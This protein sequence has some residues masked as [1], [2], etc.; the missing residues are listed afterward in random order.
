MEA[1]RRQSPPGAD[2]KNARHS[3]SVGAEASS[4]KRKATLLLVS[5]VDGSGWSQFGYSHTGEKL[6]FLYISSRF[7]VL[8][9]KRYHAI[10]NIC[11][12]I[13]FDTTDIV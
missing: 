10:S 8:V 4:R 9:S 13:L 11:I 6:G 1:R 12:R 7:P 3:G 5:Q 2:A